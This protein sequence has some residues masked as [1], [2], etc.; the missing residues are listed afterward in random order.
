MDILKSERPAVLDAVNLK[1][2]GRS[3]FFMPFVALRMMFG[4]GWLMAGVTKITGKGWFAE[5]GVFLTDYFVRAVE[6]PSVPGFYVYF[7]E[8]FA[9]QH[10]MFF[11]YAI[12][13]VQIIAG[14]F[15]I[16]GFMTLPSVLICLFMHV[17]FILSGNMNLISLV[18]YTSAFSILLSGKRIYGF[19]VDRYLHLKHRTG[20]QLVTQKAD[21]MK[22]PALHYEHVK[23]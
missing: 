10:V 3:A 19:S 23:G 7:I 16:A 2:I 5:P 20:T 22:S 12:P 18:L 21:E 11:N 8:H 6:N 17:N 15:L 14:V 4:I 1:K 9:L 13:G